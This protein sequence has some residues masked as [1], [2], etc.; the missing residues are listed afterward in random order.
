MNK[1]IK[2]IQ[3]RINPSAIY[4]ILLFIFTTYFVFCIVHGLVS[5]SK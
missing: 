2:Q 4:A 1:I 5:M 3:R